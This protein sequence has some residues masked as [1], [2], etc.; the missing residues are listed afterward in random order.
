VLELDRWDV[1]ERLVQAVVV[2]PGDRFDDRS[3][4]CD[5]EGQTRSATSSVLKL[6]A[7]ALSSASPTEPT[8]ARTP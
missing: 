3:S 2:E 5:R 4:S 8:L 6:S 1:A 7:M